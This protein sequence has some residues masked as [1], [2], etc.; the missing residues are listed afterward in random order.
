MTRTPDPHWSPYA[1]GFG[2]GL[3]LLSAFVVAG[4]GLGASGALTRF[5][6]W[7]SALVAPGAVTGNAYLGK[8]FADGA[9]PL[10]DWLVFEVLGVAAGGLVSA[11]LAGR[12]APRVEHGPRASSKTRLAMALVGGV[13]VGFA[14]RLSLGCTSGQALSGGAMLSLGSWIFMMSVFAGGYAFAWFVRK[15]WI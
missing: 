9:S 5:T 3:V 1:A 2:L 12:I 7:C 6:A 8:Y 4:Q 10:A 11:A 14:A 15:E 13:L